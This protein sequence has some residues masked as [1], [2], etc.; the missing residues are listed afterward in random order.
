MSTRVT[1]RSQHV[2]SEVTGLGGVA[3]SLG[4]LIIIGLGVTYAARPPADDPGT[5][6]LL[7]SALAAA[8]IA[9]GLTRAGTLGAGRVSRIGLRVGAA[10]MALFGA[11]HLVAIANADLGILL[12]SIF[13]VVAGLALTLAAGAALRGPAARERRSRVLLVCGLLPITAIPI[14]AATGDIPHFTGIA[15]WGLAWLLLGNT[16]GRAA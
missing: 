8:L 9:A 11:A 3:T 6:W 15:C 7:L 10:A 12:F 1:N 5:P 4:G 14:G 2:P 16:T 13:A